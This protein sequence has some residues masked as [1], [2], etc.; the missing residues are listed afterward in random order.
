MTASLELQLHLLLLLVLYYHYHHHH[1]IITISILTPMTAFSF[2]QSSAFPN[3]ALA[4]RHVPRLRHEWPWAGQPRGHP[5]GG[6]RRHGRRRTSPSLASW[7]RRWRR[8]RRRGGRG[9]RRTAER[10]GGA[11]ASGALRPSADPPVLPGD[12]GTLRGPAA[13]AQPE[14]HQGRALGQVSGFSS[15]EGRVCFLPSWY[16]WRK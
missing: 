3:P 1:P 14:G 4:P 12:E 16:L 5:D 10:G 9:R 2:D 15:F 7:R 13:P 8:R 6:E 11:S